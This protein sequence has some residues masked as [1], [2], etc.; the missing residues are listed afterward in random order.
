MSK[1]TSQ[2]DDDYCG[3]ALDDEAPIECSICSR[4]LPAKHPKDTRTQAWQH[5]NNADP[6]E[7]R[8]CDTCDCLIVIP[9]RMGHVNV[10]GIMMGKALLGLRLNVAAISLLLQDGD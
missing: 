1:E 4:D 7:G 9:A 6:F 3:E 5:G 10:E 8:C 2:P